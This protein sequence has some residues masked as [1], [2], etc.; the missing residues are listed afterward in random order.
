MR[1]GVY[2]SSQADGLEARRRAEYPLRVDQRGGNL[3]R[4]LQL[5]HTPAPDVENAG[6]RLVGGDAPHRL[7]GDDERVVGPERHRAMPG[8]PAHHEPAP[9]DSLFAD[10]ER[11]QWS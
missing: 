4:Q 6:L 9:V 1:A 3:G 10:G 2:D 11:K 8:D 5:R 7:G